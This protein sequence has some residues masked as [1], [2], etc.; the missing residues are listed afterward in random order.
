MKQLQI[1]LKKI[2]ENNI[3]NIVFYSCILISTLLVT[4]FISTGGYTYVYGQF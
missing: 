2:R 1:I 4:C 3:L